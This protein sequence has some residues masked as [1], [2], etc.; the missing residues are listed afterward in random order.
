[1]SEVVDLEK[2][3]AL[4]FNLFFGTRLRKALNM[5]QCELWPVGV[6]RGAEKITLK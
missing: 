1:M 2:L 3:K 6:V 4:A 5:V